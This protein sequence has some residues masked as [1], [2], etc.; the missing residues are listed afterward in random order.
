M[1]DASSVERIVSEYGH[2]TE[3]ASDWMNNTR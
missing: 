3:D 1:T 2:T